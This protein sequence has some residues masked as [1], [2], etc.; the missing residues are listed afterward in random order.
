MKPLFMKSGLIGCGIWL[1]TAQPSGLKGRKR[2]ESQMGRV[3]SAA[4][5]GARG[6]RRAR[7]EGGARGK[8]PRGS[9]LFG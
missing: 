3:G 4:D 7:N 6:G 5:F 2:Q 9:S 1:S 8:V